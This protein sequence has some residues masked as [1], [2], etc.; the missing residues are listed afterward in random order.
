MKNALCK[1]ALYLLYLHT[2]IA[3]TNTTSVL[4]KTLLCYR[5]VCQCF[6]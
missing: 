6:S 5:N 2:A 3:Y 1:F 4:E